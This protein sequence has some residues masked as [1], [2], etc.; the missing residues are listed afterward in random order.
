M[1][2]SADNKPY[3]A[4]VWIFSAIVIFL[5]ALAGYIGFSTPGVEQIVSALSKIETKFIFVSALILA[6][7]EGLYFLGTFFPGSTLVLVLIVISQSSGTEGFLIT[8]LSVFVGWS[9]AGLVNI[10]LSSKWKKFFIKPEKAKI[11]NDKDILWLTWFPAFRANYEV[12]QTIE[13]GN[14]IK[15]LLLSTK[16]KFYITIAIAVCAF[17]LSSFVSINQV[18]NNEGFLSLILIAFITAVVGFLK[19]R[20][21]KK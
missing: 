14:T 2:N 5:Y 11:H 1:N 10:V 8:V 18:S 12:A 6:F 19:L 16:A 13:G 17:V 15:V 9:L 21:T 4:Y 7:L 3:G 20:N